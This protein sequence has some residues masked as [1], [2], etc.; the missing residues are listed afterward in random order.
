MTGPDPY[1]DSSA[2]GHEQRSPVTRPARRIVEAEA[3]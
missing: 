2:V 1:P 3:A